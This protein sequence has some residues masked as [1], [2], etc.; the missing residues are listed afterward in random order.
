[1]RN[2]SYKND[3]RTV[4]T[5]DAGG[6]TLAFNAIRSNKE[7]TET[8]IL[9]SS[10]DN[11]D[12][13]LAVI[14]EGFERIKK[15]IKYEPAAISFAFPGPADYQN[16]VIGGYLPNFPSF[17]DGVALGPFL[18]EKF[19]VPVFIN[20]D[21]DL[22][23]YGEAF[24]GV[25]PAL[26]EE[27]EKR[28]LAK[29][30]KNLVGFT[31][32]TGCGGGVVYNGELFL[33]DNGAG[34]EVWDV[35]GYPNAETFAE[36]GVSIRAV[37]RY[38]KEFSGDAQALSPKDIFDIAEGAKE[39]SAEAARKAFAALGKA[40]GELIANVNT[41]IDGAVVLGGGV[42]AAHK[43]FMPSAIEALNGTMPKI[44]GKDFVPRTESKYFDMQNPA[45]KEAF[46]EGSSTTIKIY[47]TDKE[48]PYNAHKRCPVMISQLGT[49]RATYL[50]AYAFALNQL[51]KKNRKS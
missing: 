44:G 8:V 12:K 9:P 28:G 17:R 40:I 5:L 2:V 51:D 14:A 45:Q 11:L 42:A 19:G 21:G 37:Q 29:R 16:G 30:Y 7:I 46:F 23:A 50:G 36:E 24:A 18:K 32:G 39:G 3:I 38:Y 35:R 34:A 6:T 22:F 33:G 43:Y 26:N 1:M 13:C 20:N 27:F 31:L 15:Q 25:L 41:V 49:S 47:S 4:L 48:A 10:P